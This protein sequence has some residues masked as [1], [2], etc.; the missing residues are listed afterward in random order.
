MARSKTLLDPLLTLREPVHRH[1]QLVLVGALHVEL[2]GQRRLAEQTRR[3]ELGARADHP[4]AD[5]GHV[6]VTLARGGTIQKP[7]QTETSSSGQDALDMAS[8][9]RTLDPERLPGSQQRLAPK[10]PRQRLDRRRRQLRHV[11]DR[12][13]PNPP[14]FPERTTNQ[15]R[16]V[17]AIAM[18]PD[19]LG[20]MHRTHNHIMTQL[21]DDTT[22]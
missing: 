21:P 5:H 12:L 2:G 16:H 14:A 13:V 3:C 4:L 18:P 6:Q 22:S 7:G 10:R 20:H 1:V 19:D 11:R 17:L 15:M 8:R 9:Q